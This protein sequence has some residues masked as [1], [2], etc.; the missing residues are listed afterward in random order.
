M[1]VIKIDDITI[2]VTERQPDGGFTAWFGDYDLGCVTG[3]GKTVVAAASDLLDAENDRRI[4]KLEG[5][6]R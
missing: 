5:A 3:W 1:T 6:F 4:T 2:T